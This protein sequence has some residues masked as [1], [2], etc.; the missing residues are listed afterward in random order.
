MVAFADG[1]HKHDPP[2]AGRA[3]ARPA[4]T[5]LL[6]QEKASWC[7]SFHPVNDNRGVA[8]SYHLCRRCWRL[9]DWSQRAEQFI[10]LEVAKVSQRP[11]RN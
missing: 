7:C 6:C 8:T 11:R 9:P 1:P 3:G 5:C 10:L 2:G 4:Y